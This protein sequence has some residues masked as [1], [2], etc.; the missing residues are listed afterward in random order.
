MAN[1]FINQLVWGCVQEF[2][3]ARHTTFEVFSNYGRCFFLTKSILFSGWNTCDRLMHTLESIQE[4]STD[5]NNF[6]L[7]LTIRF[8]FLSFLFSSLI[9]YHSIVKAKK[10][11]CQRR[12]R[13]WSFQRSR[14]MDAMGA[15]IEVTFSFLDFFLFAFLLFPRHLI[16][17]RAKKLKGTKGQYSVLS[18]RLDS[19]SRRQISTP[20]K[21]VQ[22]AP[23]FIL[24]SLFR[25]QTNVFFSFKSR[26]GIGWQHP[27][28]ERT[29]RH[30][31]VRAS[32]RWPAA[33]SAGH[34]VPP[35]SAAKFWMR[36]IRICAKKKRIER[37]ILQ[38]LAKRLSKFTKN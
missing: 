9:R 20:R 32:L 14:P 38:N 27:T 36:G 2:K 6:I 37:I 28:A 31:H 21:F 12:Y 5:S 30:S 16:C 4:F 22:S 34:S 35:H 24:H 1:Q 17:V 10:G 25:P 33:I 26:G 15:S 19:S 29:E 18:L 3:G 13:G 23:L 7:T 11:R 8:V